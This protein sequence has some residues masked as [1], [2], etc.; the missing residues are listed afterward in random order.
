MANL[1]PG[2]ETT[3]IT[4]V[5][6]TDD[7]LKTLKDRINAIIGTFGGE[8]VYQEDWG[9]RKLAYPIQKEV[10]GQ[11][12]HVVYTGK[13]D[14]VA[15]IERNLRLQDSVL[16]FLTINLAKEFKKDVYLKELG[17]GTPL[18]REE[19]TDAPATG[20]T[21]GPTATAGAAPATTA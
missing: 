19:R 2:Y 7:A 8:V 1:L 3:F 13:G 14:V 4:R 18:K 12:T 21:A 17:T 6:L 10:R 20:I 9:K 5:D 16:R 15:E 11:Y